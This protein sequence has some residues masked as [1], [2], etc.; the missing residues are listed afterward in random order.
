MGLLSL[1]PRR[2]AA[3]AAAA[4]CAIGIAACG[5]GGGDGEGTEAAPQPDQ[6]PPASSSFP[7]PRGRTLA[8]LRRGVPTGPLLAPSVS[9]LERGPNRFG[10]ALFDRTRRQ[11]GDSHAALYVARGE[12]GEAHGPFPARYWS[13]QV[14]ERFRSRQT[15]GDPD[16]ARS[17]YVARPSF[18]GPGRYSVL[19]LA[20]LDNRLVAAKPIQV[21]VTG[22]SPVPEL[23]E[24]APRVST[25]TALEARGDLA[26]IDTRTPPD[27]MHEI[28]YAD[29]V[30]K[31]PVVLVFATP[32]L[33]QSRV[34]GPVVDIA[35]Q[36]KAGAEGR[37]AFI[38]M[39]IYEDN[40]VDKGFRP[41]VARFGLPSEPWAFAI[42]RRGV[43]VARLEGAFSAQELRSAVQAAEDG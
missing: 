3:T 7:K 42:D 20:R 9:A 19:A 31:R 18:R 21:R 33:C 41:Q 23:G 22:D 35:E 17:L 36:V 8:E 14:P 15:S 13:L 4:A 29:A 40:E 27:S 37:T 24:R 39:E 38:H 43:V 6:G 10:F 28:D 2:A 16:A 25:P 12:N 32:A 30:G 26:G 1:R 5:G 34:C 11:I